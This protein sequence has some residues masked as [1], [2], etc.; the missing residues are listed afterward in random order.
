MIV[1]SI[2]ILLAPVDDPSLDTCTKKINKVCFRSCADLILFV[3][4]ILH[5]LVEFFSIKPLAC[6]WYVE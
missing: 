2:F 3:F 4:G 1:L 6:V 5:D